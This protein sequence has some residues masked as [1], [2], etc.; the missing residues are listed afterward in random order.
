MNAREGD[1]DGESCNRQ[2]KRRRRRDSL[3]GEEWL[4]FDI[5]CFFELDL[6][7]KQ[8]I[9]K[10]RKKKRKTS[11]I[12]ARRGCRQARANSTVCLSPALRPS[13]S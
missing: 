10:T 4:L 12:T 11:C 7:K 13:D 1:G 8:D 9:L 2:G 6:K 3:V 5:A